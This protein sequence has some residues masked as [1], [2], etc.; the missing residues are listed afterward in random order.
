MANTGKCGDERRAFSEAVGRLLSLLVQI[1]DPGT[2][3]ERLRLA[4]EQLAGIGGEGSVGFGPS[5]VTSLP[6]GI[7]K[8]LMEHLDRAD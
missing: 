8:A 2:P 3:E 4:A 6:D 1:D 7:A 5:R